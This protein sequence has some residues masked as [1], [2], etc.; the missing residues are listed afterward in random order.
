MT[1]EL[2]PVLLGLLVGL[3]GLA[4]VADGWMADAARLGAERRRHVRAERHRGGEVAVG[5]G[6]LSAAAALV[7]RDT[8]RYGTALL[9]L[10]AVLVLAGTLLNARFLRAQLANRGVLRRGR[11]AERRRVAVPPPAGDVARR[12]HDRRLGER[13]TPPHAQPSP[14]GTA[15]G[16]PAPPSSPP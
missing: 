1:L 12:P 10:A 2:L 8:W 11:R 4:F 6:F 16:K 5:L 13:R 14:R 9:L 15:A 7:A 3:C